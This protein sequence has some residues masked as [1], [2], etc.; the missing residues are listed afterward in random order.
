MWSSEVRERIRRIGILLVTERYDGS[1]GTT[2]QLSRSEREV[3]L[4][5][6]SLIAVR[7]PRRGNSIR[8][9]P[10][11]ERTGNDFRFPAVLLRSSIRERPEVQCQKLNFTEMPQR[12]CCQPSSACEPTPHSWN[13]ILVGG[14]ARNDEVG[15]MRR[16]RVAPNPAT[17][18][19]GTR[20]TMTRSSRRC[21]RRKSM[22][23]GWRL[24][25]CFDPAGEFPAV[26]AG[27]KTELP[28][29]RAIERRFGLVPPTPPA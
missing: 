1:F 10:L 15:T 4:G 3:R 2:Q 7:L 13:A 11:G 25:L 6:G 5:S 16:L 17:E 24:A 9:P 12:H 27:R 28:L 18:C 29:E 23:R 21:A 19:F 20:A 14:T 22:R 8:E 26:L